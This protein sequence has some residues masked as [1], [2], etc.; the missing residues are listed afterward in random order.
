M[1]DPRLDPATVSKM[2]LLIVKIIEEQCP[3]NHGG[4]LKQLP[5]NVESAYLSTLLKKL[6]DY[7]IIRLERKGHGGKFVW[8]FLPPT[9]SAKPVFRD[10]GEGKKRTSDGTKAAHTL[11][12]MG[13]YRVRTTDGTQ[14]DRMTF[15]RSTLT[16]YDKRRELT[17][18]DITH[19]AYIPDHAAFKSGVKHLDIYAYP[20]VDVG[21]CIIPKL[22]VSEDNS[23]KWV[24][25]IRARLL[26]LSVASVHRDQTP[27]DPGDPRQAR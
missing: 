6:R 9:A 22:K 21:E 20:F 19:V 11:R 25:P 10:V 4:I 15:R 26:G 16:W 23:P 17:M 1:I 27:V 8:V 14:Y 2:T 12:D 18:H 24:N 13:Q 7:G 3:I 5:S